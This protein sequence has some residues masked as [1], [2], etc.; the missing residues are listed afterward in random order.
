MLCNYLARTRDLSLLPEAVFDVQVKRLH[1]YKRQHL[2]A[3][4]LIDKLLRLRQGETLP[5]PVAAIYGA[6]AAPSYE[7]AKDIL[8]LLLCLQQLTRQD[9]SCRGMLQVAVVENYNVEAAEYIMPAAEISEQISLAS[10]EASGTGNMKMMMN[11][12]LTLGTEDGANIEILQRVGRENMFLFG[13]GS[14]EVVEVEQSG[15]YHPRALYEQNERLR[16]AVDFIISR[17]MCEIGNSERLHRLHDAL[18]QRDQ[19]MSFVDFDAYCRCRDGALLAYRDRA[20]WARKM[21]INIAQSGYFSSDRTVLEYN[22]DIW[23]L[24]RQEE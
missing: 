21:L 8:H 4:Y 15:C 10:K 9:A 23:H 22:R 16:S 17:E 2:S 1:E 13:L 5:V 19:Y 24:Q 18:L 3:L 11:G 14:R 7:M 12:A 20:A 6:K